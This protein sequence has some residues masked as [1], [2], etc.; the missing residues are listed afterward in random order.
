M[1]V[2]ASA[3]VDANIT[4][5][6]PFDPVITFA[7]R[8]TSSIPLRLRIP[9]WCKNATVQLFS[10]ATSRKMNVDMGGAAPALLDSGERNKANVRNREATQTRN[11]LGVIPALPGTMHELTLP[12]GISKVVLTLPMPPRLEPTLAG[13][14][15][16]VVMRG[17]IVYA[18][19]R[20]IAKLDHTTPYD[21]GPDLLPYGQPHGQ[22]NYILGTGEWRYALKATAALTVIPRTGPT[23]D[24][25][26]GQGVFSPSLMPAPMIA[27][28]VRPLNATSWGE[29]T[30]DG[31]GPASYP[32]GTSTPTDP[33]YQHVVAAQPPTSPVPTEACAGPATR[34]LLIPYGATDIRMAAF[35]V[36][37]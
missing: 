24:P 3:V 35:P 19:Q 5:N 37:A 7:F 33:N 23:P 31:E 14:G 36:L 29:R 13:D 34:L 17:P 11:D 12:A 1:Q 8:S 15:S 27:V 4:T 26:T 18:L 10:V 6:Y 21:D 20:T 25:P 30:S 16:V 32:C 28:E 22:N 9:G 2:G